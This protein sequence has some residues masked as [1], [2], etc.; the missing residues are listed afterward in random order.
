MSSQLLVLTR[1]FLPVALLCSALSAPAQAAANAQV[2][3]S[4]SMPLRIVT[5]HFVEGQYPQP[6]LQQL[7]FSSDG[8]MLALTTREPHRQ[9]RDNSPLSSDTLKLLNIKA[10]QPIE[11]LVDTDTT[12]QF[13]VYGAPIFALQ[14]QQDRI[15]FFVGDGD[16]DASQLEYLLTERR[17]VDTKVRHSGDDMELL[18]SATAQAL[19]QCFPDLPEGAVPQ[20]PDQLIDQ[21]G[22]DYLFFQPNYH[23]VAA[24]V[25]LVKLNGCQRQALALPL[26]PEQ[27][28]LMHAVVHD[29][30]LTLVLSQTRTKD[31]KT[32]IWQT[33]LDD[34]LHNK[35]LM[36]QDVSYGLPK[37]ISRVTPLGTAQQQQLLLLHNYL[38]D[39]REQLISVGPK[40]IQQI[41]VDGQRLCNATVHANGQLAL[42]LSKQTSADDGNS[43]AAEVQ[44]EQL[45]LIKP[46]FLAALLH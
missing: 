17:V 26:P 35:P 27:V 46:A 15:R 9:V 11:T 37:G 24:N 34:V 10:K 28:Q 19:K 30:R 21:A 25:W 2:S 45:W 6:R 18:P 13:A 40:G 14:W 8:A 31:R 12:S 4:D 32:L 41:K 43:N 22:S 3:D 16:V 20:R 36:W 38:G 1:V 7:A 29:H 23:G 44:A 5:P 33:N 39:C 42:A